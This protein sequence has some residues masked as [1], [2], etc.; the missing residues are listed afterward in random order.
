MYEE[1]AVRK[2]E[3]NGMA[4]TITFILRHRCKDDYQKGQFGMN[5][6]RYVIARRTVT[7]RPEQ[8]PETEEKRIQN[9]DDP[10]S[11][12]NQIHD[13]DFNEAESEHPLFVLH[14]KL[15]KDRAANVAYLKERQKALSALADTYAERLVQALDEADLELDHTDPDVQ[16]IRNRLQ[17]ECAAERKRLMAE[18]EAYNDLADATELEYSTN[19]RE[20]V[21]ALEAAEEAQALAEKLAAEAAA[22]AAVVETAAEVQNV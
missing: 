4:A 19:V 3:V 7:Q 11:L 5:I 1:I 20:W 12:I 22:A 17:Q 15:I 18:V 10:A 14:A 16:K 9:Y 21:T 6:K 8:E 2:R 13:F